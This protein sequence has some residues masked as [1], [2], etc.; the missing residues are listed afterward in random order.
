MIFGT[1]SISRR[2]PT[3]PHSVKAQFE[4]EWTAFEAEV[5]NN[6]DSFGKQIEQQ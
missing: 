2:K 4:S 3:R 5:N 6:I 1:P